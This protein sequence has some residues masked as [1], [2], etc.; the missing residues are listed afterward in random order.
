MDNKKNIMTVATKIRLESDL[1]LAE[2][3]LAKSLTDIGDAAGSASD[4]HDNAAFDQ[5][6][7]DHDVNSAMVR[8]LRAKLRDAVII[9]PSLATE[10]VSIGNAVEVI[11]DGENEP[12]TFTVLG[13]S[14]SRTKKGWISFQTP[15]GKSLL[16]KTVGD[17]IEIDVHGTKQKIKILSILPGDF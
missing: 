8:D 5:A 6:N 13:S 2:A 9:E 14:D 3:K 15:L 16:G 12:E 4:W 17:I 10:I 11:F 7:V 1:A